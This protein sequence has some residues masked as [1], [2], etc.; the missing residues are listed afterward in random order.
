MPNWIEGTLKIRSKDIENIKRFLK[1]AIKYSC[2]SC[3][4]TNKPECY[5][6]TNDE[7][8]SR[9]EMFN[10]YGKAI[11][12]EDGEV[13]LKDQLYIKDG[14]SRAFIGKSKDETYNYIEI[15]TPVLVFPVQEAWGFHSEGWL[16]LAQKYNI[17]IRLYGIE[18]GMEFVQELEIIDG[19]ITLDRE[20]QYEDWDWQCP[21]PRMGG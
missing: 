4:Y 15:D 5:K 13:L 3:P 16:E 19:K 18:Q 20:I 2:E 17:D 6:L 21:F 8:H 9:C 7:R 1:E 12:F 10:P 14:P 11:T